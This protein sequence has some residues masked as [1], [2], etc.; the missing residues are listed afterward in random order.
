MPYVYFQYGVVGDNTQ[1]TIYQTRLTRTVVN[2][3]NAATNSTQP[4]GCDVRRICYFMASSGGLA[5]QE[6]MMPTV[7]S[8][9]AAMPPSDVDA[10]SKIIASEVQS[11]Q[12]SYYDGASWTDS[13]DGST[14]GADG[15][16]P[17]GPPVAIQITLTLQLP[18]SDGPVTYT[19]VV[20]FNA[21]QGNS[22]NASSNSGS[23]TP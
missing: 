5:R 1:V 14:L 3:P 7:T 16:T 10:Y 11:F 13:W 2:P 12:V 18:D 17:I 15:L 6:V 22:A 8:S 21:A 9:T 19:H 20:A 4:Y 23:S